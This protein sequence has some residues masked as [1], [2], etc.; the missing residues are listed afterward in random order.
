M[1]NNPEEIKANI[2][3]KFE[4]ISMRYHRLSQLFYS[5]SESLKIE[6]KNKNYKEFKAYLKTLNIDIEK[7]KKLTRGMELISFSDIKKELKEWKW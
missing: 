1:T 5:L 6:S 7:L 4:I 2:I 3:K